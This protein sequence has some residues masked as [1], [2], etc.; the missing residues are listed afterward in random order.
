M[1]DAI[2]WLAQLGRRLLMLLRGRQFDAHLEQEMRLHRELREQEEIEG[3][4]SPKQARYAAQR[5]FGNDLVLREES[6]DV[7][8]WSWLEHF[9]QDIRYGLRQLRL[10]PGFTAVAVLSLAL[11]IGANTAIFQL[12]DAVRLRNLPVPN[13]QELAE[14]RIVGGNGGMGL[15]PSSYPQLTRPIWQEIREHHEPFSEVFAWSQYGVNVGQG[16]DTR[17]RRALA[18]SDEFFGILGIR[19]WRGRLLLPQED[20]GACPATKAVVSYRYW[21]GELGGRELVSGSTLRVDGAL[22]QIVGVTPPEFFGLAVG[23]DFDIA[24]PFCQPKEGLRRDVFDTSVMG[25][26]RAAWTIQRASAQL[27]AIS[28]GIFEATLPSG[29]STQS[30]ETYKKFRLAAYPASAGVS[31]L[32]TEYDSSLWLLMGIT[33]LVLLIACANLANLMLARA[34]AREREI[35]VRLALGASRGRLLRQ[36]L[37]ESGLLA[38]I[39]AT[40]GIAIAQWLSRVLVWSIST[41]TASINLAITTDWRVVLFTASVA[42]LTCA[43]FGAVPALRATHAE[44]MATMRAGGRAMTASRERYSMQRVM[45]VTQVA[46]SL[47]LLV[48]ALLFVRS[49]RN[50]ITLD[51]GMREAGI[52]VAILA[53]QQSYLASEHYKDFQ[54]QLLEEVCSIPGVINAATTTNM[55]LLGSS[56]THDIHVGATEGWSKFTWV[57]PGYFQTMG[58]PLTMGRNFNANDAATSQRVAIVNRTF[59]RQYLGGANPIGKTLRTEPEP[60]YP[61]ATYEIVGVIADTRYSNLRGETPPMTFA[62]ASQYP[63]PGPWTFMMIHS[64]LAPATMM[65]TLKRKISEKHPEI[66]TACGNFQTWIRDGLVRERLMAM[67]SGF[68]GGLAALLAMV[69]LYG[70]ISYTVAR[71]RNEIGIR[72]ALGAKRAQVVSMVMREAGRLLVIG[73]VSGTALSLVAGRGARSLLFGLKSYDPLTLACAGAL[74]AVIALLASFLPARRASKVDPMVALR[75]E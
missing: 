20:E 3:G 26:L 49:F 34:S 27:D 37:A 12:L 1:R 71:R 46:V 44:P 32:R 17:W 70:M 43:I 25:R 23:E 64:N 50:L 36:L 29:R 21:Q 4:L 47:L 35:A 65:S 10:S 75:Y 40:L 72:L 63:A 30:M 22:V 18:V 48:G 61:S 33:G 42:A 67:L 24:L 38:G 57:S 2:E 14:V 31:L 55:P 6:R 45:V 60:D 8:G 15:N 28:R 74:L 7:W 13:P 53:Y 9:M 73:V 56:W 51:P 16:S 68:F 41:E 59:V 54:R 5:R 69:G 52:T 58:I 66:I 62:P 11:G 39:G 19:P